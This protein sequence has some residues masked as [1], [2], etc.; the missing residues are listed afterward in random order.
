MNTVKSQCAFNGMHKD[1]AK[2]SQYLA[3]QCLHH[4][5]IEIYL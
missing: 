4:R 2:T 3:I 1:Y 5:A